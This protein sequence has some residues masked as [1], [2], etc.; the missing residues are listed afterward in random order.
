MST[1]A[2]PKPP[3]CVADDFWKPLRDFRVEMLQK[4]VALRQHYGKQVACAHKSAAIPE[5]M[6]PRKRS[7]DELGALMILQTERDFEFKFQQL[8]IACFFEA[9]FQF[10]GLCVAHPR[11][12]NPKLNLP[13]AAS[14]ALL[15]F[16]QHD[17]SLPTEDIE[18]DAEN[19]SDLRILGLDTL[20]AVPC[21]V[22]R[23]DSS[24]PLLPME[25]EPGAILDASKMLSWRSPRRGPHKKNKST[26][27]ELRPQCNYAPE[28]LAATEHC[29][30]ARI[31][32]RLELCNIINVFLESLGL[33]L[34]SKDHVL[35]KNWFMKEY[36][37]LSPSDYSSGR[38]FML[39]DKRSTRTFFAALRAI[40]E[41]DPNKL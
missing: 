37:H 25:P 30:F 41:K 26:T 36:L 11:S 29:G 27:I 5:T 3:G 35:Y 33:N 1:A 7:L 28:T 19:P 31:V 18:E 12:N 34:L 23:Q 24:P 14:Q 22:E 40:L 21:H 15:G 10:E 38:P 4:L 17:Q 20:A 8:A 6:K 2:G 32:T 13:N 39:L 9:S 16:V